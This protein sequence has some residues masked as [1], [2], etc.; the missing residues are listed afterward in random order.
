VR[1]RLAVVPRPLSLLLAVAA[2]QCV[3]WSVVIAPMNGPDESAHV[4]YVQHLAETGDGPSFNSVGGEQSTEGHA[5]QAWGDLFATVGNVAARPGWT[6]AEQDRFAALERSLPHSARTD[7]NQANPVAQNPPL[8]Y[9]WNA[10]P[11]ELFRSGSLFT[12]MA[13]MRLWNLPLLLATIAFTWLAAGEAFGRRRLAQTVAAGAVGLLPQLDFMSG[14]V[15]PDNL[16]A[17]A[18]AAFAWLALA[19]LRRGP[20][21]GTVLGLA[22]A[23][24]VSV[25][26]HGRGLA[27]LPPTVLV[28]AIAFWRVRSGERPPKLLLAG[29]GLAVVAATALAYAYSSAHGG[30]SSFGG[31]I[32]KA[33]GHSFDV[34]QFAEYV[35]QFYL[36]KLSFMAPKLGPPFGY[37]QVYIEE[38]YGTFGSL[39]VLFPR[40]V[41]DALQWASGIG[42][43]ALVGAVVAAR[44]ALRR[45]LSQVAVLATML[46]STFALLHLSAYRDLLASPEPLL[47]GRY[48]FP[49]LALFGLAIALVCDVLPRRA[50]AVLAT[51]LLTAGVLLDLSGLGL[52]LARFYA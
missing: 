48:L 5:A 10:I 25:L 7:G 26:T 35:W 51:G 45:R 19:V 24:V 36:P 31:E 52:S 30:V 20:T 2:I 3:A 1:A 32:S 21:R 13:F 47:Q 28:L 12:R 27:I 15:N 44:H 6:Q 9:A 46:L 41:Y 17:A 8:Y 22:A 16:L 49:L 39:E 50:G 11:Y 14:V 23:A 29:S 43:A 4:A 37:R 42:L 34:G 40:G 38:F 33:A 18:W